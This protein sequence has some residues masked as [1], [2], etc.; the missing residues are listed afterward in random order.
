ME[1]MSEL[2]WIVTRGW[3]AARSSNGH[4]ARFLSEGVASSL[5]A[6]CS[7]PIAT[8]GVTSVI[9]TP[10]SANIR[11]VCAAPTLPPMMATLLD[12]LVLA[13]ALGVEAV[14]VA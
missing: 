10:I 3:L 9:S 5:P 1:L 7:S 11:A 8:D 12:I 14:V 4:T 13:L 6:M 2:L